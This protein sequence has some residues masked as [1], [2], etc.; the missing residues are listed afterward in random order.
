[1]LH[2]GRIIVASELE[3]HLS[4]RLI[5]AGPIKPQE[6]PRS[7]PIRAI[8][9]GLA[10]HLPDEGRAA[11]C[12]RKP[13]GGICWITN[14]KPAIAGLKREKLFGRRKLNGTVRRDR[15]RVGAAFDSAFDVGA[16]DDADG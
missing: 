14:R 13:A 1:M 3:L 4:R 6:R 9:V 10:I 12:E 7:D 11:A 5:E 8:E 15:T 16:I 2:Q